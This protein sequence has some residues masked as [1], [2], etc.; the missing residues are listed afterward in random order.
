MKKTDLFKLRMYKSTKLILDN[1]ASIWEIIPVFKSNYILFSEH[2]EIIDDNEDGELSSKG[3]TKEKEHFMNKM[4]DIAEQVIGGVLTFAEVTVNKKLKED[5]N[6]TK[7]SL[8][9]GKDKDIHKRCAVLA[10]KA[11]ALKTELAD[12]NITEAQLNLFTESVALYLKVIDEPK[13]TLKKS[14]TSKEKVQKSYDECDRILT[15]IFDN[16]MMTLKPA[17]QAFYLEYSNARIIGGWSKK[18]DNKG[19]AGEATETE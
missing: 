14:K 6:F 1:Y 12:Y 19:N 4:L 5:F 2:I 10:E 8:K 18:D 3:S 13:N 9:K 16:M 11:T 17:N 15:N 7:T